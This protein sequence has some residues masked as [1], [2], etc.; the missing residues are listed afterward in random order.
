M[1]RKGRRGECGTLV[2]MRLMPGWKRPNVQRTDHVGG[3]E[4]TFL[5]RFDRICGEAYGNL[6][7]TNTN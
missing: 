6:A 1:R 4:T 7:S 5:V 2:K 3:E